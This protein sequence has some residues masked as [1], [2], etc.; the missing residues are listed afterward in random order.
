MVAKSNLERYPSRY[1]LVERLFINDEYAKYKKLRKEVTES[2][3]NKVVDEVYKIVGEVIPDKEVIKENFDMLADGFSSSCIDAFSSQSLNTL[4]DETKSKMIKRSIIRD[5]EKFLS[6]FKVDKEFVDSKK[7]DRFIEFRENIR[8]SYLTELAIR[9]NYG[10]N[11]KKF[12]EEELGDDLEDWYIREYFYNSNLSAFSYSSE[13]LGI[14]K[15]GCIIKAPLFDMRVDSKVY[16]DQSFVHE[17]IHNI[18]TV[19]DVGIMDS[20]ENNRMANEI[21]TQMIAKNIA[22]K[23]R[24]SGVVI[25]SDSLD[26]PLRPEGCLY[27]HMF[28]LVYGIFDVYESFISKCAIEGTIDLLEK[29]FGKEWNVFSKKLDE[30]YEEYGRWDTVYCD[31]IEDGELIKELRKKMDYNFKKND[32]MLTRR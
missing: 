13:E 16:A 11:M 15:S 8:N 4:N 20:E 22:K 29:R 31:D 7:V 18:E 27:E 14:R 19:V 12:F 2:F 6:T 30:I 1:S 10:K 28:P 17:L 5:Q 24:E 25:F 23:L 9:S 32:K 26:I 3:K 21:R